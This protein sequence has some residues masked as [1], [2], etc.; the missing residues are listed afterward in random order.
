MNA[1]VVLQSTNKPSGTPQLSYPSL[2]WDER[3]SIFYSGATGRTSYFDSPKPPPSSLWSFKPD[4]TGSGAWAEVLPAGDDAWVNVIRTAYGYQAS[5]G[6]TALVLGGVA[7]SKTSPETEDLSRDTLQPG[8]LDFDMRTRRF[9]NLSATDFNVNGTGVQGQMHFV[10]SFGPDGLFVIMGGNN[11]SDHQYGFNQITLYDAASH[12]WYNQSVTGNVPRG[13]QEFC[14]AGVN[15]TE[16]TYEM[17][18]RRT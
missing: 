12:R 15:S 10:P 3:G 7:T 9:T 6:S 5:A 2:W 16:R 1:T 17:Y 11:A 13:R 14:V 4:G 8:L 18:T